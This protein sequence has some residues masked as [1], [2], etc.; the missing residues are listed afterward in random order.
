MFDRGLDLKEAYMLYDNWKFLR[1]KFPRL[2]NKCGSENIKKALNQEGLS[3]DEILHEHIQ[4]CGEKIVEYQEEIEK[5]NRKKKQNK[6]SLQVEKKL[7]FI[8]S[9][10]NLDRLLKREGSLNKEF[11]KALN[12]LERLQRMRFGDNVPPPLK[13]DL[14]LN[15]PNGS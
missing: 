8:P 6:L 7:A 11:Y 3:D 1:D 15:A 9:K 12:Q 14:D 2:K 13:I 4:L 5:L 10:E